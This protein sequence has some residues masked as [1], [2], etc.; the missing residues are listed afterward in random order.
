[1]KVSVSISDSD[2]EFLDGYA[3]SHAIAS[4]SA[5]VQK[6]IQLLRYSELSQHYEAAFNEWER[7]DESRVWDAVVM[8]GVD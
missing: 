4:R 6:A 1:M 7:D 3:R 2:M 8:D 5:V